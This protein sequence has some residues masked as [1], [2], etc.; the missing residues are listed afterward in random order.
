MD[1][2]NINTKSQKIQDGG[3]DDEDLKTCLL[4]GLTLGHHLS[5]DFDARFEQILVQIRGVEPQKVG[6]L[7]T[8]LHAVS[9]GLLLAGALL[10]LQLSEPHDGGGD[11]VAVVLF[12][13]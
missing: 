13:L 1:Q 7:F 8:L 3:G 12:L 11:L 5:A 4:L 10:E 2:I 6:H 9:F